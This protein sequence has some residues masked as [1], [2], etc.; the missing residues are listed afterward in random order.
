MLTSVTFF[1]PFLLKITAK[2]L[3]AQQPMSHES[4]KTESAVPNCYLY[5]EQGSSVSFKSCKW[6]VT[7]AISWLIIFESARERE[8][9]KAFSTNANLRARSSDRLVVHYFA[10]ACLAAF[11]ETHGQRL[12]QPRQLSGRLRA[13]MKRRVTHVSRAI[14]L[15]LV[16]TRPMVFPRAWPVEWQFSSATSCSTRLWVNA[17]R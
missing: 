8:R 3:T 4:N 16:S 14:Y 17:G 7:S 13:G 5:K 1:I 9:E 12:C 10:H 6:G 15:W 2:T 11:T